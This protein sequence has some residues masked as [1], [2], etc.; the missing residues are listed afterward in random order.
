MKIIVNDSICGIHNLI[1]YIED[2][3]GSP[4]QND[5]WDGFRDCIGDLS[6]LSDTNVE[7]IHESMPVLEQSDMLIYLDVLYEVEMSW[8]LT[9]EKKFSAVFTENMAQEVGNIIQ[10]NNLALLDRMSGLK[11]YQIQLGYDEN[12]RLL[13]VYF[14]F[15]GFC[16]FLDRSLRLNYYS[17]STYQ[18]SDAVE[19]KLCIPNRD[20]ESVGSVKTLKNEVNNWVFRD[21]NKST[22]KN[23]QRH[24]H[25]N[26]KSK[27]VF[28]E[29]VDC[30]ID[31]NQ[32]FH[33]S[34]GKKEF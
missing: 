18:I 14:L 16:F 2:K 15:D 33:C 6:W 7:I 19:G 13:K 27:I 11:L 3:L 12:N 31:A 23:G 10:A 28:I 17:L 21:C 9:K 26:F 8:R 30:F 20:D 34:I 32:V 25:V 24:F 4:Y 22:D 5:N 1:N 29:N